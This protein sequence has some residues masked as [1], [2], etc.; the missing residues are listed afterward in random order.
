VFENTVEIF[1]NRTISP[2]VNATTSDPSPL[3]YPRS[4]SLVELKACKRS[5]SKQIRFLMFVEVVR[6]NLYWNDKSNVVC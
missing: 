1:G 6:D 3:V 5:C 2:F 4:Y